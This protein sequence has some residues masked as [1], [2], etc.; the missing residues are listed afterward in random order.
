MTN[1]IYKGYKIQVD[2]KPLTD[3][4]SYQIYYSD[5]DNPLSESG[6]NTMEDAFNVAY[7]CIDWLTSPDYCD[8]DYQ[9]IREFPDFQ[10]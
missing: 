2:Y 8:L 7:E 3:T 9:D 6:W 10:G 1:E 4:W 5:R